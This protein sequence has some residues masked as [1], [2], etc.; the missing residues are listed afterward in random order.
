MCLQVVRGFVQEEVIKP[1]ASS[2]VDRAES[3]WAL[4][5]VWEISVWCYKFVLAMMQEH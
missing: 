3:K 1:F 2:V 5:A 4:I